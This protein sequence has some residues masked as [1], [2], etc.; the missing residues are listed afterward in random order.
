M[1]KIIHDGEEGVFFTN[2]EFEEIQKKILSNNVLIGSL[3][4]EVGLNE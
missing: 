2:E 3:I 4:E 1:R